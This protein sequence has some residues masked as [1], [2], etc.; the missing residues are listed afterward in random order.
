VNDNKAECTDTFPTCDGSAIT[1]ANAA[2]TGGTANG[3]TAG[4]PGATETNGNT[5]IFT[6]THS[7]G[8]GAAAATTQYTC[9]PT[10]VF[11]EDSTVTCPT[12]APTCD[13]SAITEANAAR[14]GGTATGT[15]PAAA[16]T[17]EASGTTIIFTCAHSAANGT[18]V[19]T[20]QYTC[21]ALGFFVED[22]AVACPAPAPTCDGS[23]L[24]VAN[25]TR[26]GGSATGTPPVAAGTTETAGST[27]VFTC[28]YGAGGGVAAATTTYTCGSGNFTE[29][30]TVPCPTT[31]PTCD[32]SA[33]TVANAARSG[34]TATGT[35]PAA[36]GTTE[37]SGATIIFTC[38]HIAANG[39]TAATAQYTCGG[40]GSF[41]EDSAVTCPTAPAPEWTL[42]G[43]GECSC[44]GGVNNLYN[45]NALSFATV[46][47]AKAA[48]ASTAGCTGITWSPTAY[49]MIMS[50][51]FEHAGSCGAGPPTSIIL[52]N[53]A[54]SEPTWKCFSFA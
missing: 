9:G 33:L 17:T 22:S 21:D 27:V 48:C 26:T 29:S 7:A 24:T 11:A 25:A 42:V 53:G 44:D 19:A 45:R 52:T 3:G 28:T 23:A 13:G 16:G 18:V 43:A 5:I 50:G 15:P 2:R 14:S 12:A 31:A 1:E 46:A 34:G 40:L 10:G 32:G 20:T 51:A 36:A 39:T 54:S 8:S 35:P 47:A 38:A 30:S 49:D 41:A 6:C 4:A 37:A